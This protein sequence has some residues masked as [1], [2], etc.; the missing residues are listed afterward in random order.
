MSDDKADTK[1]RFGHYQ[2]VE[3]LDGAGEAELWHAWDPYLGRFVVV[4][5]LAGHD[6]DA[7][8]AGL[9][10]LDAALRRWTGLA[11][12]S[13]QD[14]LH[15]FP[16]SSDE[17]AYAVLAPKTPP[18]RRD[19]G[20]T[21]AAGAAAATAA[22]VAASVA[23]DDAIAADDREPRRAESPPSIAWLP[24]L[25]A[26]LAILGLPAM[27]YLASEDGGCAPPAPVFSPTSTP[28]H[29]HC[30]APT[31]TPTVVPTATPR[32]QPVA[33]AAPRVRERPKPPQRK[34][35]P[36]RRARPEVGAPIA[37]AVEPP[38]VTYVPAEPEGYRSRGVEPGTVT[39]MTRRMV[40]ANTLVREWLLRHCHEVERRY[41]AAGRNFACGWMGVAIEGALP[42]LTVT[43]TQI[44][45]HLPT[46]RDLYTNKTVR[47]LC[48]DHCVTLQ[49]EA[50]TAEVY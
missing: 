26:A 17:P 25:L 50:N 10:D 4:I 24:L 21:V 44:D 47:L 22:P 5:S 11:S 3:L 32:P 12:F 49:E 46:A 41:L 31:E 36:E 37:P 16:G 34:D 8:E 7:L 38:I 18:R 30:V 9:N 40:G 33:A 35:P 19:R 20:G 43:F 6:T 23:F 42:E 29:T 39:A 27:L 13:T 2:A 28:T 14:V 15:F 45:R 48:T 1:R